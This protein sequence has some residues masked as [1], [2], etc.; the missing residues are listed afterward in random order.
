MLSH[1]VPDQYKR[2]VNV[3]HVNESYIRVQWETL[4]DDDQVW[5]SGDNASRGYE[6]H[7]IEQSYP[8]LWNNSRL[9]V[10]KDHPSA[11]AVIGP[12][13]EDRVY[14]ICIAATNNKGRSLKSKA[15]CIRMN[16][17]GLESFHLD[18]TH[19]CLNLFTNIIFHMYRK[20]SIK[21]LLFKRNFEISS[22]S[23]LRPPFHAKKTTVESMI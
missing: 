9:I 3:S 19:C 8:K 16:E 21:P 18:L 22:P 2:S 12:L 17:G 15:I 14:K 10:Q 23:L 7:V 13:E 11:D 5:N 6:I 1:L 20:S 4:P